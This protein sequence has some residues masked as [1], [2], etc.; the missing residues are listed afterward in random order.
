MA[1]TDAVRKLIAGTLG[2]VNLRNSLERLFDLYTEEAP[3]DGTPYARQDGAWVAAGGG[4]GA[5]GIV[6]TLRT[7]SSATLAVGTDVTFIVPYDLTI[8]VTDSWAISADASC[9]VVVDVERATVAA[10][11]TFNSI[12]AS[13]K[14]TLSSD[15]YATGAMTGWS[16]SLLAGER[17]RVVVDSASGTTEVQVMIPVSAA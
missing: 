7:E 16:T 15:D 11:N 12:A 14:P 4:S 13:A 10:P 5:R 3:E 2:T 6:A 1:L 17:V 8:D 9:S